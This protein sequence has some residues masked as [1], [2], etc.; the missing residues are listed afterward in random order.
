MLA[1]DW[2]H[3]GAIAERISKLA[4]QADAAVA[5]G[6]LAMA[7]Y[8]RQQAKQADKDR[9]RAVDRLFGAVCETI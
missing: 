6:D 4:Q 2:N 3:L 8:F 9:E 1:T 7:A 5:T